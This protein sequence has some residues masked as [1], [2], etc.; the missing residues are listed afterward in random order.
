MQPNFGIE[1]RSRFGIEQLR[2]RFRKHPR[3]FVQPA[4][5]QLR[6]RIARLI[7]QRQLFLPPDEQL[8]AVIL[9]LLVRRVVPESPG[10]A[11]RKDSSEL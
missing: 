7:F 5:Q 3:R 1:T 10:T 6:D 2:P 11:A 9:D 8:P 4:A